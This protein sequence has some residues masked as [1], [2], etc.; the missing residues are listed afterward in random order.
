MELKLE[1]EASTQKSTPGKLYVDGAFVAYTLEDPVRE[2][3]YDD[4]ALIEVSAWKIP[5]DTAIASGRYPVILDYSTRFQCLMPHILNVEGFTGIRIHYG[6]T[7]EDT[8]GCILVGRVR[9][10]ADVILQSRAAFEPLFTS[11]K[12]AIAHGEQIF[13]T[14]ENP[15]PEPTVL[16]T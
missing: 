4:G 9:N 5:G 15:Q 16:A 11:M 7:A 1:R 2:R 14:I 12:V 13:I 6:N 10:S 3:R 8:E